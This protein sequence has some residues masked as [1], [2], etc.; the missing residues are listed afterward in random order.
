MSRRV[1]HRV[2]Y[3][4]DACKHKATEDEAL[5]KIGTGRKWRRIV[6]SGL[7]DSGFGEDEYHACSFPCAIRVMKRMSKAL[8][9][10][11]EHLGR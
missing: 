5:Y 2:T 10:N 7:K 6:F 1:L 11:D 8:T 4:C 9:E 3:V